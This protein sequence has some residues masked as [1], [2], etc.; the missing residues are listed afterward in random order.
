MYTLHKMWIF[1]HLQVPHIRSFI[2]LADIDSYKKI[3][4]GEV[5]RKNK[6]KTQ[7]CMKK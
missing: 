6:H 1:K 4:S 7:S 3:K 2:Y 5:K